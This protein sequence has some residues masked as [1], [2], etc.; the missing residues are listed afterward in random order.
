MPLT[1]GTRLGPCEVVAEAFVPAYPDW[2][3]AVPARER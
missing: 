2:L 3:R 1:P